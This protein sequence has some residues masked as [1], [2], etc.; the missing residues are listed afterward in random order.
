MG[1]NKLILL[2]V[3]AIPTLATAQVLTSGTSD[4]S[5][6]YVY[7]RA[8][9]SYMPPFTLPVSATITGLAADEAGRRIFICMSTTL[10]VASYDN[11]S[12]AVTI[13]TF[14]VAPNLVQGL[15]WDAVRGRLIA[16]VSTQDIA[17]RI[18]EVNITNAQCTL[19]AHQ[20]YADM[21]GIDYDSANDRLIIAQETN[22]TF[23]GLTGRGVYT[24]PHPFTTIPV[25]LVDYPQKSPGVLERD[26]DGL[27]FGDGRVWLCSDEQNWLYVLN[28]A[29]LTYETPIAQTMWTTDRLSSAC[30]YAPSFLQAATYDVSIA[31]TPV[32][33]C[34]FAPMQNVPIQC[35]ITNTG[36]RTVTN[37]A[38]DVIPPSGV[39]IVSATHPTAPIANGT[40]VMLG[41]LALGQNIQTTLQVQFV[42]PGAYSLPF[43]ASCGQPE[44]SLTNNS[45]SAAVSITTSPPAQAGHSTLIF[46]SHAGTGTL[47]QPGNVTLR[48]GIGRLFA[49]SGGE[50][51]IARALC[52]AP[53]SSDTLVISGGGAAGNVII[54]RE[55]TSPLLTGQTGTLPPIQLDEAC[56]INNNGTW[57][58]SGSD[59]RTPGGI[60]QEGPHFIARGTGTGSDAAVTFLARTGESVPAIF[61]TEYAEPRHGVSLSDSDNVSFVTTLQGPNVT[62]LNQ[63]AMLGNNGSEVLARTNQS[64]PGG[65]TNG[66]GSATFFPLATI[67]SATTSINTAF[68]RDSNTYIHGAAGTI[69]ASTTF[70]PPGGVD[71]AAFFSDPD[72]GGLVVAAQENCSLLPT[73]ATNAADT[74][75]VQFSYVEPSGPRVMLIREQRPN[76]SGR[77]VVV[78]QTHIASSNDPISAGSMLHWSRSRVSDC[79]TN[80]TARPNAEGFDYVITGHN[81][82]A[83]PLLDSVAVLNSTHILAQEGDRIDLN[84]N[85]I[86]DDDAYIAGFVQGGAL[87]SATH[88]TFKVTFRSFTAST[89][90]SEDVTLGEAII[91]VPRP[92]VTLCPADFNQDGGVDGGDVES[93]F[94]AWSVSEPN[95]DV[96]IDGGIDGADVEYFFLVWTAGGC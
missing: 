8:T 42:S 4:A 6:V 56:A 37:V 33:N 86:A 48:S 13:G 93:F 9:S 55:N 10:Y 90:C 69:A 52:N 78:N 77:A 30:T 65:Q 51:F 92:D 7:N 88:A 19:L 58:F 35:T 23:A 21:C 61:S 16:S 64:V 84:N 80:I 74:N 49:D 45:L 11:P 31:L 15:A 32:P 47:L 54:A 71:A 24:W 12:A 25:K 39:T 22:T 68:S 57:A 26:I 72:R 2:L 82:H 85:S 34:T 67:D 62:T 41:S 75:P 66:Q 83:N 60:S 76:P 3:A 73:I 79:F 63:W 40:R 46:A 95:A 14:S 81:D 89:A 27:G 17:D 44:S 59:G 5:K 87:L 18:Y 20:P 29:T 38:V 28:L 70:P 91:R 96:N 50:R 94:A 36:G 1:E 43:T 53:A